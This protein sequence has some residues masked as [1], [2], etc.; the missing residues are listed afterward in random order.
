MGNIIF[1]NGCSSS[2]K[3]T[4]AIKLQQ[5]L[6]EPYQH[7]AL[8]QFRDGLPSRTR[9]LNAPDNTSGSSGL[10][11]VPSTEDG[12]WVTHIRF[13]AHGENI[14][15]AMR[16]T[17][18]LFSELGHNVIVDDLLFKREYL[19]DYVDLLDPKKVWF[20]GVKCRLDVVNQR[21]STRPGRFPGT[22]A[23][24]FDQIHDHGEVYDLELDTSDASPR[25]LALQ[26]ISRLE[27]PPEAFALMA[28]K[29]KN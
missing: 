15:K 10:N 26:I 4:L 7:I 12:K 20:I 5:L 29:R 14:L 24:H 17:V 22:A 13:G 6:D 23:A 16:R 27:T 19:D 18:A 21:E 1:L 2:G 8:D 9:G 28:A 11:V 3:T 25:E